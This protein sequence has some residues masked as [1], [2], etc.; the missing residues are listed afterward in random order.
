MLHR[1]KWEDAGSPVEKPNGETHILQ[2]CSGRYCSAQRTM[3]YGRPRRKKNTA[4]ARRLAR[5]YERETNHPFPG[6]VEN[7]FIDRLY[8][9]Y[10][11]RTSGAWSWR[12]GNIAPSNVG[13][14]E[15]GSQWPA[16]VA[17]TNPDEYIVFDI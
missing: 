12:L 8:P 16:R 2:R 1:H 13:H 5:L 14:V 6:G 9:G 7:A 15:M 4:L 3:V 17:I 10:W 11:Q